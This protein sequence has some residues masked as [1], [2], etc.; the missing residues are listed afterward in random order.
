M[1]HLMQNKHQLQVTNTSVTTIV[2]ETDNRLQG[3]TM[4][5]DAMIKCSSNNLD[6]VDML[7][8]NG[9]VELILNNCYFY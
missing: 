2:T 6:A 1:Q 5:T 3:G 7:L 4:V 8:I 9:L